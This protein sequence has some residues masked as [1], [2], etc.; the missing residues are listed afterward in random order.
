MTIIYKFVQL[1]TSS[2]KYNL[3]S[4]CSCDGEHLKILY[5]F[6]LVVQRDTG[7]VYAANIDI[8]VLWLTGSNIALL[9]YSQSEVVP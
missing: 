3:F 1:I 7:D 9:E 4:W 5:I 6:L 2:V 8:L